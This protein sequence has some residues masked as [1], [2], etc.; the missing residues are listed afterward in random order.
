MKF[1]EHRGS[2]DDSLE[3]LVEVP[4]K[5]A[6]IAHVKKLFEPYGPFSPAINFDGLMIT[7]Y[8][9]RYD[10][11]TGWRATFIVT[12]PGLGPV[13]YTDGPLP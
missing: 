3:T 6:L 9:A 10:H 2:T 5:A 1:R 7:N 11:R 13:G 4:D 8:Y 12:V